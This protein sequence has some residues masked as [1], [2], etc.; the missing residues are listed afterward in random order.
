MADGG[1]DGVALLWGGAMPPGVVGG[2]PGSLGWKV[3]LGLGLGLGG[4]QGRGW[5]EGRAA[6]E[7]WKPR[8]FW[9]GDIMAEAGLGQPWA[10]CQ[11]LARTRGCSGEGEASGLL[12]ASMVPLLLWKQLLCGP[13]PDAKSFTSWADAEPPGRMAWCLHQSCSAPSPSTF[14]TECPNNVYGVAVA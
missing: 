12:L 9:A 1:T 3:R 14:A 4:C 7:P 6:L 10:A 11:D 2:V 5:P 13:M 8:P